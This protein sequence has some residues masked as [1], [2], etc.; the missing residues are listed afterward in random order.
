[1]VHV[2]LDLHEGGLERVVTDLVQSADPTRTVST[3]LCL[4]RRGRLADELAPGQVVLAP[5]SGPSSMIFPLTLARTLTFLAPDVVH[6]HSGAWYKAVAAAR[7]ARLGPVLCTDHGRP[8]PDTLS[9]RGFDALGAAG[10]D[11]V[12]AVSNPLAHYLHARLHVSRRKL[13]VI[14]NGIRLGVRPSADA[15]AVVRRELGLGADVPIL[16]TVG[17]LDAV[18]AHDFLLAAFRRLRD[19]WGAGPVPVLIIAGDGPERAQLLGLAAAEGLQGA[20]HF[21]G[22]RTDVSTVLEL[23]DLFVLPSDSEGTSISLLEAMAAERCVVATAVGGTPDVLGSGLQGQLV[24]ARDLQSLVELM[25]R[26]LLDPAA[27]ADAGRRSRERVES[28]YSLQAM[29]GAYDA[30]YDR[31]LS[32]AG[33]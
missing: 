20:V 10:A 25:R 30:L 15:V 3:V 14:P 26:L 1:V 4:Q 23:F 28:S 11:L 18:K 19:D 5:S 29:S 16:G 17:R 22:W 31:L 13:T 21:L 7:L 2:V 12:V 8:V 27:R 24:P 32:E 9:S 6:V 33:H